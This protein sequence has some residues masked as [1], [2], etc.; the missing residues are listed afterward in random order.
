MKD[1]ELAQLKKVKKMPPAQLMEWLIAFGKACFEDGLRTGEA[2]GAWW[3]D[4][5]V[6]EMLRSEKIGA[7]RARRIAQKLADGPDGSPTEKG[8]P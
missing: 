7:E 6:F 8:D 2:E 1:I 4:E 5:Q 3:S